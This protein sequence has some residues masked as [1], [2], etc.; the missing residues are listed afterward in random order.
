MRFLAPV[1]LSGRVHRA[2]KHIR[3]QFDRH[4]VFDDRSFF[5]R[6]GAELTR[7]SLSDGVENEVGA[8]F[9]RSVLMLS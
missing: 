8:E 2:Q 5:F 9:N 4:G 1:Y 7:T 6:H 3:Q